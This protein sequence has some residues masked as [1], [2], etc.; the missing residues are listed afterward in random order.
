MSVQI[1][2]NGE[3]AAEAARELTALAGYMTGIAPVSTPAAQAE[4]PAAPATE[5]KRTRRQKEDPAPKPDPEPAAEPDTAAEPD[6]D[7]GDDD[8]DDGPV[9][10]VVELRAKAQEVGKKPEGRTAVKALLDKYEC[11]SISDV[12][13][14]KRNAFLRDLEG[15]L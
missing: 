15:L 7:D 5:S 8:F 4:A 12:P 1:Q 6:P 14:G 2:I 10:D 9:P 3:N 13:E 11:K